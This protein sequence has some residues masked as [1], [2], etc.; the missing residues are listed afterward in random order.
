MT[1]TKPKPVACKAAK[2]TA[3]AVVGKPKLIYAKPEKATVLV[4][5]QRSASPIYLEQ[6]ELF[7]NVSVI[8][9]KRREKRIAFGWYGGKYSHLDWLLPLLPATTHFCWVGRLRLS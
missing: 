4:A 6:S 5:Q 3:K 2:R 8:T 7:E 1:K 9:R